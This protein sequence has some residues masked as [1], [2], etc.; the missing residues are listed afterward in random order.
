MADSVGRKLVNGEDHVD[1]TA[2]RQPGMARLDQHFRSQL[3]QRAGR[4]RPVKI[5]C[6]AITPAG[7]AVSGGVAAR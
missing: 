1:S 4:K 7:S 5:R 3:M 6:H 2:L